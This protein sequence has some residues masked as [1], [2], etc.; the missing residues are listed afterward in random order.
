MKFRHRKLV[1][2][3]TLLPR[4]L[5]SCR[6]LRPRLLRRQ[7]LAVWAADAAVPIA[8][9]HILQLVLLLLELVVPSVGVQ[10]M[11]AGMQA[12]EETTVLQLGCL[13]AVNGSYALL[14]TVARS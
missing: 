4:E 9:S 5:L 13:A 7:A 8:L 14:Q 11:D 6:H 3:Q 10:H 2:L 1:P 12:Q